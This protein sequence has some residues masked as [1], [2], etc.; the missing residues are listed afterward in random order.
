MSSTQDSRVRLAAFEFLE[1]QVRL[2]GEVLPRD[3]L[4]TGFILDGTRVPLVGPQG[5][6]KPRLIP[7]IPFSITTAPSGPYDDSF[8]PDGLLR[9]RY[10]G[11]NPR[12][13]ENVALRRAMEVRVPLAYFHGI[14][15]GKYL[16]VWPVYIVGDDPSSLTFRVAVDDA[17]YMSGSMS[18]M[19]DR[20][21]V[22]DSGTMARRRYI[23]A[24]VKRRLHQQAFRA[25]VLRAYRSQC[26][27][28]RLRHDKLLD[29]AHIVPDSEPE[30]KPMV[31]NGIAVCKLHHAAYDKM[32]LA[33]RPDF[34]IRVRN[35]V[36]QEEDGPMLR[37]GLQ[38][39]HGQR[40]ILPRD[41][42]LRPDPDLLAR[43]Y[44]RFRDLYR[45]VA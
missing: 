3:T 40:I 43:Q 25:R 37:H 33:I 18:D 45:S 26:A 42:A 10:R 30:G 22:S 27:M 32:F 16:A 4:Q 12:H 34:L 5:I 35:D 14:L 15:R 44:N 21:A 6:F 13:H 31:S 39:L 28:C 9:Y 8:G 38:G 24:T 7:E 1:E 20:T 2:H 19:R 17:R 41:A 23:T 11:N 36:L 29:A